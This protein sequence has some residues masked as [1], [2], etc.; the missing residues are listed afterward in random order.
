MTFEF[1]R[2]LAETI[3]AALDEARVEQQIAREISDERELGRDGQVGAHRASLADGLGDQ[4]RVAGEIADCRID[5]QQRNLHRSRCRQCP[6]SAGQSVYRYVS[7]THVVRSLNTGMTTGSKNVPHMNHLVI[8]APNWLGDAVMALPAI[9]DVSRAASD[10]RIAVAA[11]VSIAPLFTLVEGVTEVVSVA[12]VG[13]RSFDTA[14]LLP[15]SF[16]A[17]F[18]A[19]RAGIPER[20]GYGT[21]LRGPLLTRAVAT[22]ARGHQASSYQHLVQALGFPGGPPQPRLQAGAD[23][24]RAGAELLRAKGWDEKRPLVALAPGAAYGSAKR[25]PA[26]SFGAVAAG[27][28]RD[29]VGVVLIGSA[30]DVRAGVD[31]EHVSK[32]SFS[33]MN[34]IGRTDLPTLAG[35]L[36]NCRALVTNDSGAMHFAAALGVPVTAMFGPTN[37]HET[38][39]LG[40]VAPVVL[41]HDVWCRPCMLREC[42]IDHRCMRGITVDGVLSS[43][44]RA[45]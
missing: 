41:T 39:P 37:E 14:L 11:Q 21:E 43:V 1:A 17:A 24:R 13:G 15:N 30:G 10:A 27:L 26:E 34:L 22:P 18:V 45:L 35:V 31:V 23:R 36:A 4:A 44:R 2:Q 9:A 33:A 38:R 29:G 40:T 8:F 19:W 25:W 42:P 20:W 5:L 6:P 16:H 12:A 32:E 28:A 7:R 3:P